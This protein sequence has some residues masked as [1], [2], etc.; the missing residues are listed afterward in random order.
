MS[1]VRGLTL[2]KAC[3]WLKSPARWRACLPCAAPRPVLGYP[4]RMTDVVQDAGAGVEFTPTQVEIV[5]AAPAELAQSRGFRASPAAVYLASLSTDESRNTAKASMY[6]I[7]K[8]FGRVGKDAWIHFP[9]ERLDYQATMFVRHKL[10]QTQGPATVKLTLT[11]L[12]QVLFHAFRLG[13]I[14][15]EAWARA[16]TWPKVPGKTLERGRTLTEDELGKLRAYL[17]ELPGSY[18]ELTTAIFAAGVGGGLRRDEISRLH[19]TALGPDGLLLVYGKG[20]KERK[21]SL[22]GGAADDIRRWTDTRARLGFHTENLFV[23]LWCDGRYMDQPLSPGAVAERV[24]DVFR[25]LGFQGLSA[26][27][28]RRTYC[29]RLLEVGDIFAV[30]P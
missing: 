14:T 5:P 21:V 27:D 24:K 4:A 12:R 17:D 13:Y 23:S 3:K 15:H 20:R 19:H 25:A 11:H 30:Q 26:H 28:M 9:W 29:T 7:T 2:D 10:I 8:V 1:V 6:R 22:L 18:G 16:T